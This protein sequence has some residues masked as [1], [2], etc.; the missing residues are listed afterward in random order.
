MTSSSTTAP[1]MTSHQF[2]D[3]WQGHGARTRRVID[4]FRD[5]EIHHRGPGYVDL[6]SLGIEPPRFWERG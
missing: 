3:H 6:R 1:I 2:L 4:A 5:N